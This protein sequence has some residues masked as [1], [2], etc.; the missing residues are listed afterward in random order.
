[1]QLRLHQVPPTKWLEQPLMK[2]KSRWHLRSLSAA[3]TMA[4]L[5]PQLGHGLCNP[6]GAALRAAATA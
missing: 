5:S 3:S 6:L 2:E 1:M 4:A